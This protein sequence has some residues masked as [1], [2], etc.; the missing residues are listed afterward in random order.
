MTSGPDVTPVDV[1]ESD[2]DRQER[3]TRQQIAR[4]ERAL[5]DLAKRPADQ[6]P[7]QAW[8]RLEESALR[9]QLNDLRAQLTESEG[10]IVAGR[11]AS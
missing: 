7:D 9:G 4:F 6:G 5:D 11:P 8:R 1:A 2:D 10:R 3:V